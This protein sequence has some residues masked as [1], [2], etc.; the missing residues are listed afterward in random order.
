MLYGIGSVALSTTDL[1][2][3]SIIGQNV[4]AP[5]CVA[6]VSITPETQKDSAMCYV[7][8]LLQRASTRITANNWTAELVYEYADWATLQL[9]LGELAKTGAA[10]VPTV[11]TK[12]ITAATTTF[13]EI[14]TTAA[15]IASFKAYNSTDGVFLKL[16]TTAPAASNEYQ[17][18]AST[19]TD[20]TVIFDAS[21]VGKTVSFSYN[22]AYS[23][24]ES[25][26]DVGDTDEVNDFALSAIVS[27]A[28]DGTSAYALYA[29]KVSRANYPTIAFSGGSKAVLTINYDIITLPGQRRPFKMYKLNGATV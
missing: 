28:V 24:I 17:I 2:A 1:D 11:G 25:I 16:V 13:T 12:I 9:L 10:L 4:F 3:T 19:A 8:G 23:S 29:P 21:M 15:N 22:K 27:S 18:S 5:Q 6:S 20:S 14:N 7:D 26:G